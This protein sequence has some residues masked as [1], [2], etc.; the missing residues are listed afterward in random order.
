MANL[1]LLLTTLIMLPLMF[2]PFICAVHDTMEREHRPKPVAL[3]VPAREAP[4]PD[5][6]ER[7]AA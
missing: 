3:R 1:L 7:Q 5:L 4:T 2:L 6:D